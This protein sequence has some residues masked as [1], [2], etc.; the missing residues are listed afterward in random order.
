MLIL[1]NL[2]VIG[3]MKGGTTSL[4]RYLDAHPQI[5]MSS[6]KELSFFIANGARA[7]WQQGLEWY[8]RQF[9]PDVPVRGESTPGYTKHPQFP[10]VPERM[11]SVVPH[12]RLVY[13]LRDPVERAVS[14]HTHLYAS[15]RVGSSLGEMLASDGAAAILATSCY[16]MQLE[17]YL[18]HFPLERIAI[19]ESEALREDPAGVVGGLCRWLGVDGDVPASAFTRRHHRTRDKARPNALG[20]ALQRRIGVQRMRGVKRMPGARRVLW[21]PLEPPRVDEAARERLR[22]RLAP[23]VARLR[24]LTGRAFARWSL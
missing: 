22:E 13:V 2:V 5:A 6:R 18:P 3:A 21:T 23:D 20:R 19:L 9:A 16:A 8:G 10:G 4:H 11:V 15:A 1:P 17:R 7:R 12:A 14:H 24:A